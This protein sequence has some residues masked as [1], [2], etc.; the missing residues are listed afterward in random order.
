MKAGER[1]KAITTARKLPHTRESREVILAQLEKE[2]SVDDIDTFLKF[3]A[4]GEIDEQDVSEISFGENIV[5]IFTQAEDNVLTRIKALRDEIEA[6]ETNAGYRKLPPIRIK[7]NI[8]LAPDRLRLRHYADY[9]LDK[10]YANPAEAGDDILET[11]R[12]MAEVNTV[13]NAKT[14]E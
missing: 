6:P 8:D 10:V 3:I 14:A 12:K 4:I 5:P 13:E 1:D 2:H 9:L 7:D 11:L